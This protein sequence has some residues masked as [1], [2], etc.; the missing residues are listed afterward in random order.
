MAKGF[1]KGLWDKVSGEEQARQEAEE[2]ERRRKQAEEIARRE[3]I[4][5]QQRKNEQRRRAFSDELKTHLRKIEDKIKPGYNDPE[6]DYR[7]VLNLEAIAMQN[8]WNDTYWKI[9]RD[10][11]NHL[12]SIILREL[13]G[14]T[15]LPGLCTALSAASC[16]RV[17]EFS[18]D[19]R[20][21][22]SIL[23]DKL[24]QMAIFA[25]DDVHF[26][27]YRDYGNC[28]F[29]FNDPVFMKTI[30]SDA[31][32][33]M[34]RIEK[35]VEGL[36]AIS[37]KYSCSSD[38]IPSAENQIYTV[39]IRNA[40]PNKLSVIKIIRDCTGLGL[41]EAKNIVEGNPGRFKL[42]ASSDQLARVLS[43]LNNCGANAA[44]EG[45]T[46]NASVATTNIVDHASFY[47]S[48]A[49]LLSVELV[50]SSCILM[51]YYAKKWPFDVTAFDKARKS[52]LRH[53]SYYLSDPHKEDALVEIGPVEEVLARV[54]AKNRIGGLGTAKQEKSYIDL[55]LNKKIGLG[56][57]SPCFGLAH[58]LAWME[59]YEM[60]IDILRKLIQAGADV[61]AELQDRLT[62]LENGGTEDI[63]VYDIEPFDNIFF[64]DS[65]V[66]EWTSKDFSTF[67]RKVA[68]KKM[69]L[70]YSLAL[71]KWTK[72]LPL[73]SGQKISY[74]QLFGA[75]QTM[76][77]DFD[78][79]VI[80]ELRN[81][82][83]IN[84]SNVVFPNAVLFTFKSLR[85]RC[86][87]ILFYCEKFGRNLNLTIFTLFTPDADLDF[88]ELERYCLAIKD[89]M[90]V[91]SFRESILQ[92][93]DE[94]I[95]VKQPV[96][97]DD[98]VPRKKMVFDE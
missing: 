37:K 97:D 7:T 46:T 17:V 55:W 44:C 89:N 85:N 43:E 65:S 24:F 21:K 49:D 19:C 92:E 94:V 51:W 34:E 27:E 32:A 70:Q 25:M 35:S 67:F 81:A 6:E 64:F 42:V 20:E 5:R 33:I 86:V 1:L 98:C 53:T 68:M 36:A 15:G 57:F 87:D 88:E 14:E 8:G 13:C 74:N 62:F 23:S 26:L 40:G 75:F 38:M 61:P 52:Y 18:E 66:A 91:E 60:E 78:G 45:T 28:G 12:C 93:V 96:Y 82:A 71:T 29:K 9:R 76:V 31:V 95:K 39:E 83:A 58:G 41:A 50:E 10:H 90:Y 2:Q 16:C 63:K 59:L 84:L 11:C 22:A 79:E 56:D 80:C 69:K 54:Y 47:E 4:A 3:E 72:T 73:A 30:E 77:E 48:I